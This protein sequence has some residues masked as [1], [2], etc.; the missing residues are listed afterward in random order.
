MWGF[1]SAKGKILNYLY[2]CITAGWLIKLFMNLFMPSVRLTSY[3]FAREF[4]EYERSV[5][6]I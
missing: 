1:R 4:E 6:L 2:L 3:G 5:R